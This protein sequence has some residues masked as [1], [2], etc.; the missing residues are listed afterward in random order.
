MNESAAPR[1]ATGPWR[2]GVVDDHESV[3]EGLKSIIDSGDGMTFVAGAATVDDLLAQRVDMDLVVLDLRLADGSSPSVNVATLSARD[4][5][6]LVYTSGDELYLVR[7]AAAAG[8]MG[9]L[10]KS[11]GRAEIQSA[12]RVAASG[13]H[14]ATMDWAAAL[15][16][17]PDFVDLPPRLRQVLQL[18][19][20]GEST[21][22]VAGETGLSAETVTDYVNRIRRRY[23]D[24]GRPAP[25]KTD[26][27]KRAVEDGWLPIPRRFRS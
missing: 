25:T 18:Y 14:V 26:L 19:A 2:V 15:D 8:V 16:S 11:V 13:Q 1:A 27:F 21:Q 20:S 12:I 4:I 24:A 10:R 9:V 7:Q 22:R 6:T 3:V 5:R 23:R 17:D